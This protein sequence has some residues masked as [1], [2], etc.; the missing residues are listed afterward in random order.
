MRWLGFIILLGAMTACTIHPL[1]RHPEP[2]CRELY[3]M[4]QDTAHWKY[5]S[6]ENI[7]LPSE[8]LERLFARNYDCF[9]G[10]NRKEVEKMAGEPT[11]ILFNE[12]HHWIL[13]RFK[14]NEVCNQRK[15]TG[16]KKIIFFLNS[17]GKVF[18]SLISE[19]E[20]P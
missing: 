2:A 20:A 11:S 1:T 16:C 17:E 12:T 10:L 6:V 15:N 19:M 8:Q 18:R 4:F 13:I 3:A 9:Q 14:I 5:D 7:Y